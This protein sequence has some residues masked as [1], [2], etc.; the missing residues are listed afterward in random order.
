MDST[1]Q[2]GLNAAYLAALP[3]ARLSDGSLS[4]AE[5]AD[6]L[7]RLVATMKSEL[8]QHLPPDEYTMGVQ[9][10]GGLQLAARALRCV[11]NRTL[12]SGGTSPTLQEP[13][14]PLS[15][16]AMAVIAA[17]VA[18]LG[19]MLWSVVAGMPAFVVVPI[20]AAYAIIDIVTWLNVLQSRG[21]IPAAHL[22]SAP[23]PTVDTEPL[24][25][26]AQQTVVQMDSL[27]QRYGQLLAEVRTLRE[28]ARIAAKPGAIHG[29]IAVVQRLL[30]ASR[31]N[32]PELRQMIDDQ[33]SGL[34]AEEG[35]KTVHYGDSPAADAHFDVQSDPARSAG[36]PVELYP[37]IVSE[38]NGQPVLRGRV[39]VSTAAER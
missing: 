11:G 13:A 22:P 17:K 3:S 12:D 9:S 33:C 27:I 10:L 23:A 19:G 37:A 26:Q 32:H 34:L 28:A 14:K 15:I 31:R 8:E 18:L 25:A 21:T 39:I 24:Q 16:I 36:A 35:L 1:F 5:A 29:S 38:R 30:G 20:I 2:R 6:R 7:D 4:P